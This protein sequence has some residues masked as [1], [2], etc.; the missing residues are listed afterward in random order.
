MLKLNNGLRESDIDQCSASIEI[1]ARIGKIYSERGYTGKASLDFSRAKSIIQSKPCSVQSEL[2]YLVLRAQ[3]AARAPNSTRSQQILS[4]GRKLWGLDHVGSEIHPIRSAR[5][6]LTRMLTLADAHLARS[7]IALSNDSLVTAIDDSK[8]ALRVL[9]R[10]TTIVRNRVSNRR[11]DTAVQDP[12]E[13]K[14]IGAQGDTR[15]CTEN[16]VNVA[17]DIAFREVQWVISQKISTCLRHLGRL[18]MI[19]GTWR[20]AQ[21][22]FEQG[23]LLGNKVRSKIM[24]YQFLVNISDLQVRNGNL[25]KCVSSLEEATAMRPKGTEFLYEQ[26][27]LQSVVGAVKVRQNSFDAAI[28]SF[29]GVHKLFDMMMDD[30]FI[31]NIDSIKQSNV[32][33]ERNSEPFDTSYYECWPL[34]EMQ[35]CNDM[36]KAQAMAQNGSAN[37]GWELLNRVIIAAAANADL[38]E[39]S[40]ASSHIRHMMACDELSKYAGIGR[41]PHEALILP[42]LKFQQRRECHKFEH[43]DTS[44]ALVHMLQRYQQGAMVARVD[45]LQKLC[46]EMGFSTF[47]KHYLANGDNA[48][49]PDYVALCAYYLEMSKATNIRREMQFCLEQKLTLPRTQHYIGDDEWPKNLS[50]KDNDATDIDDTDL[51]LDDPD[52]IAP[53]LQEL[54]A[55]YRQEHQLD[56]TGFQEMFV[57]ILPNRWTVCSL[58][59]DP[60]NR[61]LYVSRMRAS[62]TPFVVKLPLDRVVHRQTTHDVLQYSEAAAEL[63]DIIRSSDETIHGSKKNLEKQEV[64]EWWM[65]RMQLDRRLKKLLGRIENDWF[66]GFRAS[67]L[68]CGNYHEHEAEL[69]NFQKLISSIITSAVSESVNVSI[70]ICR[71]MLRLGPEPRSRDVEDVVYFLTSC[72]KNYNLASRLSATDI[73]QLNGEI[74]STIRNYHTR[75]RRAG[76]DTMARIPGDHIILILDKHTHMFPLESMPIMRPQA[77]SRLPCISFLRDRIAY[78][79]ASSNRTHDEEWEDIKVDRQSAYY[80]LNPSGDLMNTQ[81]EFESTFRSTP[82]WS[83]IVQEKPSEMLCQQ[84]L[85]SK[86]LYLYFGHSAGQAFLR[87]QHVRQVKQCPVA[88]LMGCS[89]GAL[90]SQGDYDP[91]GYVMNF[92]LGGSP[93]VVANLWDVTDKS[94]D[95]VTKKIMSTWGLLDQTNH[96]QTASLVESV[97]ASRDECNLPYLIGAAPVVYGVPVFLKSL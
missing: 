34:K 28:E 55:M 78:G 58:T 71:T 50:S 45:V 3:D 33:Q 65:T 1:Y 60:H 82:G 70:D 93:C 14:P 10:C 72:Y 22:C 74:C 35:G 2:T 31:E 17:T 20:E 76:I 9:N 66:S 30:R 57:D 90:D 11:E 75:S 86:E 40:A 59:M 51:F 47:F 41:V 85:M 7:L 96:D 19:H 91:S 16:N 29:D 54:R 68:L 43:A 80:I 25:E 18:H 26:A 83:G 53:H 95:K 44:Q 88:L 92:L 13:S 61:D 79:R 6:R 97:V 15:H 5:L 42:L 62:E 89:S 64:N 56:S 36:Q 77:V 38:A 63:N 69:T 67:G 4:Q 37:A 48:L 39:L 12:F 94:I 23:R 24:I 87:G 81:R 27:T 8:T 84:A 21:Y 32:K 46:V 49:G 52:I 73:E